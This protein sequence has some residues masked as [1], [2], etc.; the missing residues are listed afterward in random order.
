MHEILSAVNG[1]HGG[2][3]GIGVWQMREGCSNVVLPN[4]LAV[5]PGGLMGQDPRVRPQG[6]HSLNVFPVFLLWRDERYLLQ[7]SPHGAAIW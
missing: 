5:P 2:I 7:G 6:Q 1:G 3:T 4:T